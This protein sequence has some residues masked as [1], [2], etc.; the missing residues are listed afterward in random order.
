MAYCRAANSSPNRVTSAWLVSPITIRD[1]STA[2]ARCRSIAMVPTMAAIGPSR[3]PKTGSARK[4]SSVTTG[5]IPTKRVASRP[6]ARRRG[7]I[8]S[9]ARCS[10]I[11]GSSAPA[12]VWI[13]A[14]T[15]PSVQAPIVIIREEAVFAV[16]PAW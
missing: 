4:A 13:G 14:S 3:A 2:I 7:A 11:S 5:P 16:L 1:S 6:F 12:P 8:G 15:Q 10:G 9:S